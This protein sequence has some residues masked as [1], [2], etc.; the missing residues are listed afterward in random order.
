[1]F[2]T[3]RWYYCVVLCHRD[4]QDFVPHVAFV[5]FV[6]THLKN[7]IETEE[8]AVCGA[9]NPASGAEIHVIAKA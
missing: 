9:S 4:C 6:Y 3:N 1:M 8:V 7:H 5:W 2:E